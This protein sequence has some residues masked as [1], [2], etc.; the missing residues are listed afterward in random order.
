LAVG[1]VISDVCDCVS[2]CLCDIR[3]LCVK[4]AKLFV[5]ILL[6]LDSPVILVF[7]HQGLLLNSDGFTPRGG[8]A[9]YKGEWENWA[10]FDQ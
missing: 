8:G 6:P 5:E 4:T 10:I 3:V 7:R 2:V 1:W 9:K